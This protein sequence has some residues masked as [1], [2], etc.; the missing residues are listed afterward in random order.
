[1]MIVGSV[2]KTDRASIS[3][4][5]IFSWVCFPCTEHQSIVTSK[6]KVPGTEDEGSVGMISD[7]YSPLVSSYRI[8][9]LLFPETGCEETKFIM[10]YTISAN[11]ETGSVEKKVSKRD[12]R[13]STLQTKV[14]GSLNDIYRRT[15]T[16]EV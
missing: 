11:K 15:V 5:C 13:M 3:G 1:M 7:L 9:P 12:M 2:F 10:R 4:T 14:S 16:N 6:L 8:W